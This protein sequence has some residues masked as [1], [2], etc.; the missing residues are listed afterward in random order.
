MWKLPSKGKPFWPL[1]RILDTFPDEEGV[2]RTVRV[3]KPD[4]NEVT[5]NVSHLIPLELYSELNNP[6]LYNGASNQEESVEVEESLTSSDVESVDLDFSS[7]RPSRRAAEASRAQVVD[8]AR[9]GLL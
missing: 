3:V 7:A 1:V 6:N 8:L 4:K 2:I 5:V 9:R